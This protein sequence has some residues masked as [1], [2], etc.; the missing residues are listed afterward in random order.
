MWLPTILG[1]EHSPN[2]EKY[3]CEHEHYHRDE[4]EKVEF[5]GE[6]YTEPICADDTILKITADRVNLYL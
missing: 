2:V 4:E 5:D 1:L 6:I 3:I